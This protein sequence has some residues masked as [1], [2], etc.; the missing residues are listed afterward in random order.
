M[1]K[2]W[3][4]PFVVLLFAVGAAAQTNTF[5][6][7]GNVGIGTTSPTAVLQ[8]VNPVNANGQVGFRVSQATGGDLD[9]TAARVQS[10]DEGNY[11]RFLHKAPSWGAGDYIDANGVFNVKYSGNVGIGTTAPTAPLEVNGNIKLTSGSGAS[12]TYPDGTV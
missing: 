3:I 10:T 2:R 12:M 9:L 4:F 5:P 1:K 8:V 6:T 7:S 11:I